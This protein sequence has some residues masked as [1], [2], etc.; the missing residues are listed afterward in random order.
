MPTN[1]IKETGKLELVSRIGLKRHKDEIG[2][3]VVK[4]GPISKTGR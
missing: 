4:T 2:Q 3:K 1:K